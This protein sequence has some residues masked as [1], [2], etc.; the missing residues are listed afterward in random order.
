MGSVQEEV[1]IYQQKNL[2]IHLFFC[3]PVVRI[4]INF[5]LNLLQCQN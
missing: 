3:V 5:Y 4:N 1:D 2:K